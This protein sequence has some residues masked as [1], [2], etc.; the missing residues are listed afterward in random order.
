MR[1]KE[2]EEEKEK[3]DEREVEVFIS[4][5]DRY[6]NTCSAL[7]LHSSVMTRQL[8]LCRLIL[9]L[10]FHFVTRVDCFDS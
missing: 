10:H 4:I 8:R 5:T 7:L 9:I 1:R 6:I 2:D 3:K